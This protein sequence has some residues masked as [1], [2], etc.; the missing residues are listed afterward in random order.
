MRG[1]V[2]VDY[3][4]ETV[5]AEHGRVR[6]EGVRPAVVVRDDQGRRVERVG[7]VPDEEGGVEVDRELPDDGAS[8]VDVQVVED[9]LRLGRIERVGQGEARVGYRDRCLSLSLE[10]TR[11]RGEVA[12]E[13][14]VVVDQDQ[15]AARFDREGRG[16]RRG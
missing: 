14:Y 8:I 3:V 1:A 13:V 12:D 5:D 16:D 10:R 9:E 4:I 2:G 7:R 15:V 11:A 6:D